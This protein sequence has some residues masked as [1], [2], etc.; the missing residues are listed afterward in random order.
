MTASE[1]S[2]LSLGQLSVSI[3]LGF[4]AKLLQLGR[5]QRAEPGL[6]GLTQHRRLPVFAIATRATAGDG[7][8]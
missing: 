6:T 7:Y 5:L 1:L 2:E 3:A 4:A 8:E